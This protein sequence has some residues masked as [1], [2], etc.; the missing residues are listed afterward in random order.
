MESPTEPPIPRQI[1]VDLAGLVDAFDEGSDEVSA[2]LDLE[3]GEVIRLTAEIQHELEAISADLPEESPDDEAY[4]AA[5]AAALDRRGLPAWRHE[6]L[7]EAD[8]VE[9]GLGTRFLPVP[10]ADSRAGYADME[11]FIETV[12]SL[13]LQERLRGA[14]R[15]RGAFRR[16]KD[17]LGRQPAELERWFA[18]RDGRVRQRA[19]AWLAEE[20]IE[21]PGEGG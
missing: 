16:F 3:S 10:G 1:R 6:L 2:Y 18:F 8:A 7:R 13:R 20:G 15:G 21:P 14:I 11:A 19:L 4:R 9:G 5:F 12:A 17:V